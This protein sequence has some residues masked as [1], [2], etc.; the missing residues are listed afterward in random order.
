M[1][2]AKPT[3]YLRVRSQS[4]RSPE[5]RRW[6]SLPRCFL[7]RPSRRQQQPRAL[8]FGCRSA[9]QP[10]SKA[11]AEQAER[12]GDV[13]G[14]STAKMLHGAFDR[15]AAL[16]PVYDRITAT[17]GDMLDTIYNSIGADCQFCESR[18]CP[19]RQVVGWRIEQEIR[20]AGQC[21]RALRHA[22]EDNATG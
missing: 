2:N 12:G 20:D 1:C 9:K 8:V 3:P 15:S 4:T 10:V 19:P 6:Y 21:R 17:P 22:N 18:L 14:Q 13:P 16:N 7:A 11:A 5:C